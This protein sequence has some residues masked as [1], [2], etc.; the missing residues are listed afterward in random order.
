[1][2]DLY[3][4]T[5]GSG[6]SL[7]LAQVIYYKLRA[8]KNVVAN[9]AIKTDIVSKNGKKKIGDFCYCQ[10]A[11]LTPGFLIKYAKEHHVQG[12]ESQTLLAIDE[13]QLLFN[14]RQFDSKS[15]MSWISFFS[16]HRKLGYDVILVTQMDRMLDRQIRGLI[17]NEYRHKKL[18]NY[19]IFQYIPFVSLFIQVQYWYVIRERLTSFFFL[20]NKKFGNLYDTYA[21]FDD[22]ES[23]GEECVGDKGVAQP[24]EAPVLP[25]CKEAIVHNK[26]IISLSKTKKINKAKNLFIVPK[27]KRREK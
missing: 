17:E 6:K 27:I 2:I 16:Q 24:G 19:K 5:P 10:N 22:A 4:G 8:K 23:Q 26:K 7:K 11:K 15:R 13:A 18:N 9:F 3:T 14:S 20:Y 12:K 25:A 1:M 21:L